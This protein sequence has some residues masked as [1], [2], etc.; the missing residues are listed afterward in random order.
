MIMMQCYWMPTLEDTTISIANQFR[1]IH[2]AITPIRRFSL[3]P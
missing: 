2:V 3:T 1:A